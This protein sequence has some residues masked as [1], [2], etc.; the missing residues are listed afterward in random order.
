MIMRNYRRGC[1]VQKVRDSMTA[2]FK[3]T[4]PLPLFQKH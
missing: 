3:T 4:K 1:R 2:Q